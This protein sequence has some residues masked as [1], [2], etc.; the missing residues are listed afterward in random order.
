MEF[1]KNILEGMEKI[2]TPKNFIVIMM[3]K[4]KKKQKLHRQRL[5]NNLY[6]LRSRS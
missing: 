3:P 4:T 6:Y 2:L 5:V 1:F